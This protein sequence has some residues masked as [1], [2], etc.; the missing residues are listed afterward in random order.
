MSEPAVNARDEGARLL[1][2]GD[3]EGAQS[4][5]EQAVQENPEDA[6]ARAFLGICKT[7]RGDAAGGIEALQAATRLAPSDAV[8]R[9]N[10]GVALSQAGRVDDARAEL[11][12]ALRLNPGHSG[13]RELLH[14]LQGAPGALATAPPV[15]P[16]LA[17]AAPPGSPPVPGRPVTGAP[18]AGPAP[19]FPVGYAPV[20]Q[21]PPSADPQGWM[22]APPP[23]GMPPAGV[24]QQDAY[25]G[26][27][28][29]MYYAQDQMFGGKPPSLGLRLLRGWGWGML[30]G[31][32]WTLWIAVSAL[33]WSLGRV[34]GPG[35][36]VTLAL[37]V[38]LDAIVGSVVGLIIAAANLDED[39]GGWVGVGAG[40]LLLGLQF[41]L[42]RSVTIAIV[43]SLFFYYTTG[44]EVGRG[45][46]KRIRHP[47]G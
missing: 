4:R 25:T 32:W 36:A 20:P 35:F 44:R 2:G 45:L 13:A 39:Q 29:A 34:A 10:L 3:L 22:P 18:V 5:L 16:P 47:A 37:L 40:M 12:Q 9:Y 7:R 24:P 33:L 14:R 23:A 30:Y 17:P 1:Q 15:A 42:G 8:L 6:R 26:S 19:A 43:I 21:A 31:Q 38:T 11:E 46:A 27:P 28:A 41:L